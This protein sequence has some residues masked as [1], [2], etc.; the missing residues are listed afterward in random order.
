MS[1]KEWI[2]IAENQ[3]DS[4]FINNI[5]AHVKENLGKLIYE[6]KKECLEREPTAADE[7]RFFLALVSE[8]KLPKSE[9]YFD[10]KLV[11]HLEQKEF[12]GLDI[13]GNNYT[14]S[15]EYTPVR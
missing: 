4:T 15:L 5:T 13:V 1:Q 10:K 14:I 2:A 8:S 6:A 9:F 12:H 11:G 3:L 7:E